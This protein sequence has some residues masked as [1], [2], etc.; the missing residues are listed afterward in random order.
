MN[1]W[2]AHYWSLDESR[3]VATLFG[4]QDGRAWT[5]ILTF[6]S[7]SGSVEDFEAMVRRMVKTVTAKE[8]R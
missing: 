8:A 6:T 2:T 7:E 5:P 4:S 3:R 1:G